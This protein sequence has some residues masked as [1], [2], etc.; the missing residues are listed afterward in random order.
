MLLTDVVHEVDESGGGVA[1]HSR[2][3]SYIRHT[4]ATIVRV[5]MKL[6]PNQSSS[7]PLSSTTCNALT[8]IEFGLT[9]A[10]TPRRLP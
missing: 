6:E 5:V 2:T 8:P 1:F 4:P 9:N 10:P 3:A 7:C